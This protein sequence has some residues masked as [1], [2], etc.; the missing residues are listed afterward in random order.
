MLFIQKTGAR[1]SKKGRQ[2]RPVARDIVWMGMLGAK[3]GGGTYV[4]E[5]NINY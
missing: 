2:G 3:N 1:I 5:Y 4:V